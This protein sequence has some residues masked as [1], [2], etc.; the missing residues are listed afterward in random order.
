MM[1]KETTVCAANHSHTDGACCADYY[2]STTVM[3]IYF[4]DFDSIMIQHGSLRTIS[5]VNQ[6]QLALDKMVHSSKGAVLKVQTF[7]NF[8]LVV[9]GCS[10]KGSATHADDC[11]RAAVTMMRQAQKLIDPNGQVRKTQ[12][13]ICNVYQ[14]NAHSL[15]L[16]LSHSRSPLRSSLG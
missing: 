13:A 4:D 14:R 5:W 16:P 2:P 3:F 12:Q 6:V 11:V 10:Q 8:Y 7:S 9:A 1:I 15:T